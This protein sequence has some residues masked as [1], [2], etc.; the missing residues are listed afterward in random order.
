[1]PVLI[2]HGQRDAIVLPRAVDLSL[3]AMPHARVS[4]FEDCGHSPFHEDGPRFNRELTAFIEA[5]QG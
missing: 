1:V 2:T 4:W 3:A 5:C